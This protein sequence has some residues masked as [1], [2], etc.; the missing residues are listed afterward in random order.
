MLRGCGGVEARGCGTT[1]VNVAVSGATLDD[2]LGTYGL[3]DT[4][5]R[6][7]SR[8]LLGIDPW[9]ESES[10][11]G[12]RAL[13]ARV[14]VRIVGSYDPRAA[15]VTPRDFFDG[16]HL[17]PEALARIARGSGVRSPGSGVRSS[18][19]AEGTSL[20]L[21]HERDCMVRD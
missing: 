6:R 11:D 7:P 18:A 12:W 10:G 1:F 9:M 15:G 13:S 8:V 4:A 21:G 14:G 16:D 5:D 2:V 19:R 17:R 3:Y 20:T